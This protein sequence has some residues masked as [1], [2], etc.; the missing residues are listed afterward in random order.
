MASQQVNKLFWLDME[1]TGL[2]I[3]KEVIIEVAVVITDLEFNELETF[4]CVIKQPPHYLA[5]M[6]E[7]NTSHHTKSGLLAKI[8][9]GLDEKVVE[10]KLITLCDKHFQDGLRDPKLKPVLAGNSIMQDRM[11]IDKYMPK[12]SA[13]LHYRML[14]VSSWKIMY[15]NKFGLEYKKRNQHRAVDD[16]RESMEELRFYMKHIEKP[17]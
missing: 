16:I 17:K 1:M 4:D 5:N 13:R 6:D 10:Q 7:W 2:D 12:F 9:A 15:N 11:F 14:D 8:P 3:N